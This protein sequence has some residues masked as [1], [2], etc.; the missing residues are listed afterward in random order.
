MVNKI[1]ADIKAAI[2]LIIYED[3]AALK[4]IFKNLTNTPSKTG[5]NVRKK[6]RGKK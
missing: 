3:L 5:F 6:V 2:S 1:N 4:N